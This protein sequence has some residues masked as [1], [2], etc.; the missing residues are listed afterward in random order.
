MS[1]ATTDE[2]RGACS[3]DLYFE[4]DRPTTNSLRDEV[5]LGRVLFGLQSKVR[6]GWGGAVE[7]KRKREGKRKIE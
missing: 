4:S 2:E 5:D 1:A 7:G 3:I 6:E